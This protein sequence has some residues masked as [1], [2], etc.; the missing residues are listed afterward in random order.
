MLFFAFGT[1]F[2]WDGLTLPLVDDLDV[3]TAVGQSLQ[4]SDL[5]FGYSIFLYALMGS[6]MQG[7]RPLFRRG[8]WELPVLMTGVATALLLAFEYLFINFRSFHIGGLRYENA[9]AWKIAT[10]ALLSMLAAPV[11][12]FSFYRLARAVG[13]QIRYDGLR[14]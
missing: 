3:G 4:G 8:R 9:I 1:G 13:Y 2:L 6:L 11:V 7:I 14:R 10:T 5:P 12:F